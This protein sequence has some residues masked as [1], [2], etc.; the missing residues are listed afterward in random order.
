MPR[1][2]EMKENRLPRPRLLRRLLPKRRSQR[3]NW[4]RRIRLGLLR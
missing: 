4:N 1:G 3:R 2:K